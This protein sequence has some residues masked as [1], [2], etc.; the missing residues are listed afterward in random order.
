M[1]IR[2]KVSNFLSFDDM[3]EFS[4]IAGKTRLKQEHIQDDE[5]NVKLLKFSA[6]FGANSSGKSSL[7]K[8]MAYAK[9]VIING[10]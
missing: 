8:A 4:M 7:L 10:F 5:N 2:F 1:L 6:L 3:Q 9:N